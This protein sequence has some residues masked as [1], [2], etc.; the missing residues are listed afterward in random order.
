MKK[1][2]AIILGALCALSVVGCTNGRGGTSNEIWI[3]FAETGY[4]REYLEDWIEE[5]QKA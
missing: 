4:G 3:A 2:I 5:F 1:I